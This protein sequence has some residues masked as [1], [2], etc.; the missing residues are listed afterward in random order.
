[1][2]LF[3]RDLLALE[4]SPLAAARLKLRW[5]LEIA[6]ALLTADDVI[7]YTSLKPS[8]I[9]PDHKHFIERDIE[10]RLSALLRRTILDSY[11]A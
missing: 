11:P 7:L 2:M 9:L 4:S 8:N 5:I 6:A 1:M 10:S 3:P